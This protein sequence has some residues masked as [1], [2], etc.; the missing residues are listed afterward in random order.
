MPVSMI[1]RIAL[2]RCMGDCI[3]DRVCPADAA[4]ME[5]APADEPDGL[6]R[7][8]LLSVINFREQGVMRLYLRSLLSRANPARPALGQATPAALLAS[9]SKLDGTAHKGRPDFGRSSRE[10]PLPVERRQT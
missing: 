7:L 6:K 2:E 3:C 8:I 4:C 10:E 5:P 9:M 1:E